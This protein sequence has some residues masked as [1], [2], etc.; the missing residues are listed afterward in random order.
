MKALVLLSALALTI[1]IPAA[2]QDLEAPLVPPSGASAQ[3]TRYEACT[4]GISAEGLIAGLEVYGAGPEPLGVTR[5]LVIASDGEVLA[6]RA[7]VGGLWGIGETSI[8]IPWTSVEVGET[9]LRSPLL[10]DNVDDYTPLSEDGVVT[11]IIGEGE[12]QRPDAF[13]ATE[14]I[15]DFARTRQG[16]SGF[17]NFGVI[18]DLLIDNDQVVAIIIEP[19]VGLGLQDSYAVTF[20]DYAGG[21]WTT[22]AS[23]FDLNFERDEMEQAGVFDCP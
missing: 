15:G 4:T 3:P 23:T 5:D 18:E 7:R 20:K 2:A 14:L 6:L 17:E 12:G 11:R 16:D 22:A 13:R 9:S 1:P 10:D 19:D 21:E 8:S